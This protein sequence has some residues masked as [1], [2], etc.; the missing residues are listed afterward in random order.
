VVS[1]YDGDTLTV[2]YSDEGRFYKTHLRLN[3]IDTPE[4]KITGSRKSSEISQLEMRAGKHVRNYV[5][6]ITLNRVLRMK[7]LRFDKYGG[8]I[9]GEVY[10]DDSSESLS[11]LLLSKK[12]AKPYSGKKK[13]SWKQEE[14]EYILE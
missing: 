8:R 9:I 13:E 1:V 14:L 11:N 2:I 10:P 4:V 5:S 3:G 6:S 12:Y 7:L